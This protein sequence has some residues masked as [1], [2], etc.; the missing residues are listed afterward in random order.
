MCPR[1]TCG[2]PCLLMATTRSQG[3]SSLCPL[4]WCCPLPLSSRYSHLRATIRLVSKTKDEQKSDQN[5]TRCVQG[6]RHRVYRWR[7]VVRCLFLNKVYN[8]FLPVKSFPVPPYMHTSLLSLSWLSNSPKVSS[9]S[10]FPNP[11][12][13]C[14]TSADPD[15]LRSEEGNTCEGR[16]RPFKPLGRRWT[17]SV[18]QSQEQEAHQSRRQRNLK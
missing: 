2:G 6:W 17:H 14:I 3:H 18:G 15:S 9:S 11:P 1:V 8:R 5:R 13:L 10:S 4:R 16:C 7:Q 12:C